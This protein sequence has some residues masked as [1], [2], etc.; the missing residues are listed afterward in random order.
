M[1]RVLLSAGLI[2]ASLVLLTACGDANQGE[3]S[4][5]ATA[6]TGAQTTAAVGAQATAGQDDFAA[7]QLKVENLIADCMKQKGF[8]YVPHTSTS[9]ANRAD[10]YVGRPSL[11]QS[12]DVV[13]PL[14]QKYGFG[15][16]AKEVYPNDPTVA[17]PKGGATENPNNKIREELDDAQRAAYDKAM[18]DEGAPGCVEEASKTVFG[19]TD[20]R[21]SQ[22]D[23]KRAIEKFQADKAV[24]AAAQQYADCL[25]GKGY[26]ITTGKPGEV[27]VFLLDQVRPATI[28][29]VGDEDT[30]PGS[31]DPRTALA[32]EIKKAVADLD[33]RGEYAE[34]VRT[35]YPNVVNLDLNQG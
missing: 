1:Q 19:T 7:R 17:P 32:K 15:V 3:P 20:L 33:C 25:R 16:A 24:V 30:A 11:L 21:R 8:S 4:S 22:A 2:S 26:R 13:R 6:G 12:D 10:L 28:P 34:I 35:R 14:R 5:T 29:A 27:E 23:A 31:G 18:G 9:T